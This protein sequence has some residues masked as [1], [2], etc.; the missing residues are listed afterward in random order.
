METPAMLTGKK[1][2]ITAAASGMGRAGLELFA[3]SGAAVV[4]IDI[5]RARL[6][7]VVDG[8]RRSGGKAFAVHA[9]LRD[10]A[11]CV[12]AIAAAAHLLDGIDILWAHAG[13]PGPEGIEGVTQSAYDGALDLNL[14]SA[15]TTVAEAVPHMRKAGGG[16]VVLTSSTAGLTGAHVSPLYAAAKHAIVGLAKSLGMRYALENIRVNAVCPGPIDTPMFPKFFSA[17]A[18]PEQAAVYREK[19][20]TAIPMGRMG[21]AQEVAEAALW[22]ASDK[23]SF[24]TGAALAVD[25]GYTAK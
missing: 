12:A 10:P 8:I 4:G 13:C 25:G 7:D 6:D 20:V 18:T 22:L 17:A 21:R 19:V 11:A 3:A 2:V 14:R 24:V 5:D 9:D 16:A 15:F 23:A 1:A